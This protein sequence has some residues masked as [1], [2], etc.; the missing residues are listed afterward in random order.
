MRKANLT[1]FMMLSALIVIIGAIFKIQHWLG[2]NLL[3]SVGLLLGLIL[4]VFYYKS[5]NSN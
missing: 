2:A 5:D 1:R 3:M 4:L